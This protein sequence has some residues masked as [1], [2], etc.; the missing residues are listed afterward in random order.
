MSPLPY[1]LTK[2]HIAYAVSQTE[3]YFT[4]IN[5][6]AIAGG[7]PSLL[8]IVA[9]NSA[10]GLVSDLMIL[11]LCDVHDNFVRNTKPGGFPDILTKSDYDTDHIQKGCCGIEVKSTKKEVWQGHNVE[12]GWFMAIKYTPC[13][14]KHNITINNVFL[15]QLVAD[16]WTVCPRKE[17]S[18]RTPTANINK[19][20]MCKLR[21]CVL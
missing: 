17:G 3:R 14:I 4:H 2:Q 6:A 5:E 7:Y 13:N 1:G 19:N 8:Q 12:E 21:S 16:D 18:R 10:P 15:A 20:G 11:S 9:S